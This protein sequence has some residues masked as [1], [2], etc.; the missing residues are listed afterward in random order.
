MGAAGESL[1]FHLPDQFL[2]SP[3]LGPV[4]IFRMQEHDVPPQWSVN[5]AF[6]R[7]EQKNQGLSRAIAGGWHTNHEPRELDSRCFDQRDGGFL[8]CTVARRVS[9]SAWM[10]ELVV[11]Q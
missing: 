1:Q 3:F 6:R 8:L 5:H 2:V 4:E 9:G 7:R 11:R 10:P